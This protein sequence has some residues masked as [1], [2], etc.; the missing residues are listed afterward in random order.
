MKDQRGISLTRME[1]MSRAFHADRANEVASRAA[2]SAGVLEAAADY[3]A[4]RRLPMTFSIDLKPGKITNQKSSGR[5]WIFA[6]LNT[7]RFELM[8]RFDLDT[9]ELSQSYLFFYDKLEKANYFLESVLATA[10]EPIQG[11]LYR[12]L[13]S[14]PLGDGGQWDMLVNLVEKYGLA[15]REAYP[16]AAAAGNSRALNQYLTTKLREDAMN[17]RKLVRARTPEAELR[18]TKEEMIS[19]LYRMLCIALGEPPKRFDLTLRS[20]SGEVRQEFGITPR[21]FFEKYVG[22]DLASTVSLIH[23]PTE[24]KPYG[25][26]YTVKFL[27]NVAEGRPVTYLNLPMERIKAAVIAQL[28][29]GHPVWFGSD[30]GKFAL[31]TDGVFDREAAGVE[32]LFN[33]TFAFNKAE[34]LDYGDS[35][36][37][38][39][40]VI[41]GVNLDENGRPDRWHIENSWG[42]DAGKDGYFVASDQWFDGFVY[43]AVVDRKYLEEADRALLGGE[44]HEL[45]PWD[46]FGTLA[47]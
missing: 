13:N 21:E 7:F 42:P 45:E 22:V 3:A 46:P 30:C 35:A 2:V 16:D 1:D 12:F 26:L 25:H 10:D 4:L 6:A 32:K 34:Y 36:M 37:N 39:A 5:C 40:M 15:P 29:D 44:L 17:L 33:T 43:Q 8:R 47:D 24:D 20:R 11:R 14:F 28:R 9:F 31:R 23:A 38:H 27:G 41:L 19:E 18:R